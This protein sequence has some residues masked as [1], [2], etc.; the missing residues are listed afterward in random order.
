LLFSKF[1]KVKEVSIDLRQEWCERHR[2]RKWATGDWLCHAGTILKNTSCTQR[3]S[4]KAR[5]SSL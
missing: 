2:G 5:L 1:S 3:I 4:V